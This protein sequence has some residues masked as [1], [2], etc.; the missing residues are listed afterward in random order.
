MVMLKGDSRDTNITQSPSYLQSLAR[1]CNIMKVSGKPWKVSVEECDDLFQTLKG[2]PWFLCE[3][4]ISENGD[5]MPSNPLAGYCKS[6]AESPCRLDTA[7]GWKL[8]EFMSAQKPLT[9][10]QS[11]FH[12]HPKKILIAKWNY[13]RKVLPFH[14]WQLYPHKFC[15]FATVCYVKICLLNI[16]NKKSMMP[17]SPFCIQSYTETLTNI[18]VY[19]CRVNP[20]L[21]V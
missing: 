6:P 14:L 3:E 20:N 12:L 16:S 7:H 2:F 17:N 5:R 11:P 13:K 19:L 10:S 4:W 18:Q 9:C 1:L 8:T 21:N 15:P